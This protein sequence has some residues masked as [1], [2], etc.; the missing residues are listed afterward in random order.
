[1]T[2]LY[3]CANIYSQITKPEGGTVAKKKK[4]E[5]ITH[6]PISIY[7]DYCASWADVW[8]RLKNSKRRLIDGTTHKK[9][10]TIKLGP[11]IMSYSDLEYELDLNFEILEEGINEGKYQIGDEDHINLLKCIADIQ[12]VME[13]FDKDEKFAIMGEISDPCPN[14]FIN[15]EYIT[16]DLVANAI[17]WFLREAGYVTKKVELKLNWKRP[18]IMCEAL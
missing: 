17:D 10:Q 5:V 12:F 6:S 8:L 14:I 1:M 15:S 13:A 18:S 16:H 4:I 11:T 7:N 2:K 9:R 3:Y